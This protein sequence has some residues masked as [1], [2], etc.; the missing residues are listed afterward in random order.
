M[1]SRFF[2]VLLATSS[3][4]AVT[5]LAQKPSTPEERARLVSIEQKLETSPLDPS[6]KSE[7]EWAIKWL[8]EVPDVRVHMC[9]SIVGDYH[10]YKYSSEI[11]T[12]IMLASA[13]FS[14][15]NPDKGDD[16]AEQYVLGAE[17]A[18]RAYSAILQQDPKAKSKVLDDDLEKQNQGKLKD[19]L[20][21][22][23]AKQCSIKS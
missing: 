10:K 1:R 23:A 7:R 5:S 13:K 3:F 9:P 20:Q 18:L 8:I 2:L 17:S 22:A 11:T 19:I 21:D 4:S 16:A 15:E 6:L 12:Q 14:I